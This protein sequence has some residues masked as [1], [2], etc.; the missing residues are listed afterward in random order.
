MSNH[1]FS[2]FEVKSKLHSLQDEARLEQLLRL[3]HPAKHQPKQE[4]FPTAVYAYRPQDAVC[5]NCH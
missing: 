1:Y 2:E 5:M 4:P 3:L